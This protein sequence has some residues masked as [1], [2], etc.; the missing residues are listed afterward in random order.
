M[1]VN[2]SDYLLQQLVN[3]TKDNNDSLTAIREL[4]AENIK[5]DKKNQVQMVKRMVPVPVLPVIVEVHKPMMGKHLVNCS[6]HY[7]LKFP[8]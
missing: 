5:N 7:L 6:N 1:A 3:Q 2:T 8:M 4:L